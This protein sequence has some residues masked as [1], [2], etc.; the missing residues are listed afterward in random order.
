[1][2]RTLDG[3]IVEP[4]VV[5]IQT[6]IHAAEHREQ[7]SSMLTSLG[8]APPD[9]DGWSLGEHTHALVPISK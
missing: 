4:W 2:L 1:M 5:M 9:L 3:Y 7:I 6:I 8:V